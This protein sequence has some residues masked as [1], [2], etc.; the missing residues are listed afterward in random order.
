[1]QEVDAH[2]QL[3]EVLGIPPQQVAS[4]AVQAINEC[5]TRWRKEHKHKFEIM[6]HALDL[7][8]DG[9]ST[10]TEVWNAMHKAREALK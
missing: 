8:F 1:M 2:V 10:G 7:Y 6:Q 5:V 4:M 9:K 3:G